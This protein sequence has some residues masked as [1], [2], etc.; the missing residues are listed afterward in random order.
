[1]SLTTTRTSVSAIGQEPSRTSALS[2]IGSTIVALVA[3]VLSGIALGV[4]DLHWNLVAPSA[5]SVVANSAAAWATAAFLLALVL[6][7]G[8]V[9]SAVAGVVMLAVAVE[10]YY[11][12]A[13]YWNVGST[14]IL[15]S[16]TAQFWLMLSV[17]TG[18][19]FGVAGSFAAGRSA[20]GAAIGFAVGASLCLGDALH[21]ARHASYDTVHHE[22]LVLAL[23]GLAVLAAAVPRPRVLLGAVLLCVPL[24]VFASHV[25]TASQISL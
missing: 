6:R 16:T 21:L 22:A 1:M 25:L 19:V 9:R 7:T 5:W 12:A 15:T 24:S 13:V 18:V 2:L 8:P 14:A 17:A 4:G 3:A 20:I 23:L 10:A 11:A